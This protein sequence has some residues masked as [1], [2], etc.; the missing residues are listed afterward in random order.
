[1]TTARYREGIPIARRAAKFSEDALA[2][3]NRI[4]GLEGAFN[5]AAEQNDRLRAAKTLAPLVNQL[6]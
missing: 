6:R 1:M 5:G 2:A 4:A 3:G